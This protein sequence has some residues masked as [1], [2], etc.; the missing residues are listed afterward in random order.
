[1][2]GNESETPLD[3]ILFVARAESRVRI[4]EH[5]MESES[6]TQRE[7]RSHLDAARTTVS[8]SLQ[9]LVEKGW[10]ENNNGS[11]QLTRTGEVLANEF[12]TMLET[13]QTVEDL[14]EF[15]RWFPA[16][17]DPPDFLDASDVEVTYST[18]AAPYAAARKQSEIL[19]SADQLRILLP[20]TDLDSTKTITQQVTQH[21][22]EVETVV[23]PDVGAVLESSEF[24]PLVTEMEESDHSRI[25]VAQNDLPFYLGLTDDGHVQIGLADDEGMPR[26]LL[27]TT[28][29]TIYTWASDL[30]E[31]FRS[32][33]RQKLTEEL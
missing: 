31:H 27:E 17:L 23:S 6:A 25:Y 8:R 15:L 13:I 14:S 11:Y 30:Y 16:D 28:D 29:E 3:H 2:P 22:L 21:G 18:D 7:L 33:S 32:N 10:V 12:I 19:Y 24:A 1:M 26:A 5:L 20:A 9:S 4:I